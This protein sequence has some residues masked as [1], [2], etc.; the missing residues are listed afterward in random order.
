MESPFILKIFN[1]EE[2]VPEWR[3][4]VNFVFGNGDENYM[5]CVISLEE[6]E[7][8]KNADKWIVLNN[9]HINKQITQTFVFYTEIKTPEGKWILYSEKAATDILKQ[10]LEMELA[11]KHFIEEGGLNIVNDFLNSMTK[12]GA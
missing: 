1:E 3:I 8:I 12:K 10:E 9:F 5:K 11:A 7:I 2:L 6:M 4:C